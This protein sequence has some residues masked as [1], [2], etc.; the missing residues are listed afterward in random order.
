MRIE[1]SQISYA[2][3]HSAAS[4]TV[5]IDETVVRA[6]VSPLKAAPEAKAEPV[7]TVR[8]FLRARAPEG[9]DDG[10]LQGLNPAQRLAVL[11]IEALVGHRI[12]LL[13]FRPQDGAGS[14]RANAAAG[15]G[16][17]GAVQTVH[18][19]TEVHSESEQTSF[20]ARGVVETAD[21]RHIQFS[22]QFKLQRD[23]RSLTSTTDSGKTS[24]PLVV[25]FGGGSAR[26][27]GAKVSFDLNSDGNPQT[28]SFVAGGS[29]F[30]ALDKNGDGK[31]ND[32][33][34]L[35]G[36]QTGNGFAELAAYD[37]DGNGWIDENDPIFSQLRIWS[38]D[39]LSTLAEKGIGAIAVSSV[40]TPFALKDSANVSRGNILR[41]GVYLSENGGAG[42]VQQ[43]DLAVG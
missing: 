20:Q 17:D 10:D 34:E 43:V 39:G 40:E 12:K 2:A 18:R 33:R 28:I 26:L 23:F 22:V 30:L 37:S 15:S 11:A 1:G 25:N 27:T 38:E 13:R 42:T 32:G 29:G 3:Q 14:G 19:R 4:T 21:G 35:F 7:D 31:V 24:D 5:L 9:G 36:P 41:S 16:N 8:I 6:R